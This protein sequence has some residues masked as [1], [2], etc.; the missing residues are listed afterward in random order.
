MAK[1]E[2]LMRSERKAAK[3]EFFQSANCRLPIPYN[4]KGIVRIGTDF[5]K[6]R[7]KSEDIIAQQFDAISKAFGISQ[8]KYELFR[9]A[10]IG[11]GNEW[12]EINQLNSSTLLAFL[13]FQ[14]VSPSNPFCIT[15]GN[16]KIKFT[17]V[18]F[19]QKHLLPKSERFK[20]SHP[21][22]NMDIVLED[23]K[24]EFELNLE[25]KFTEY[26]TRQKTLSVA[27]YYG[28]QYD[29]LF[30]KS[31]ASD[32]RIGYVYNHAKP[33]ADC[34]WKSLDSNGHYLDGIK[35]MVSHFLGL[36]RRSTGKRLYLGEI[37][38]DFR[39]DLNLSADA[40]ELT[41]YAKCHHELYKQLRHDRRV[42]FIGK[43]LTYQN[44]F[45][46]PENNRILTQAVK[47]FYKL[48]FK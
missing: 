41:D 34:R 42:T 4:R 16:R 19:E 36:K 47:K 9:T 29:L 33:F 3:E 28:E 15:L 22:S 23:E 39:P 32:G 46:S 48:G 30:N 17:K 1:Q 7:K 12:K 40:D 37:V 2:Q 14:N 43:L 31:Y 20:K 45:N 38:F 6:A 8:D 27:E 44:L 35:Q 10:V 13:C 11:G 24:E 25:S 21:T 26:F 5:R 18:T